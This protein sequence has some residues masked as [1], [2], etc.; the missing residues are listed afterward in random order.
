MNSTKANKNLPKSRLAKI[1]VLLSGAG[2]ASLP[3]SAGSIFK[4]DNVDLLSDSSSWIGG[5]APA[6]GDVAVFDSAVTV[7]GPF[8]LGASLSWAG[9]RVESPTANVEL[10]AGSSLSLGAAGVDLSDASR[11]LAIQGPL[12]LSAAQSWTLSAGRNVSV[13]G[14]LSR[15]NGV[16]VDFA[17]SEGSGVLLS[18]VPPVALLQGSTSPYATLNRRDFAG[19]DAS[20]Q[21]VPGAQVIAYAPNPAVDLP[22]MAGT[23]NGVID[24]VNSGSYGIRLGNTL[25]VTQ[26]IRFSAPHA[27]S[28]RW[29]VD[30]PSGRTLSV[31]SILVT[32]EVGEDRV[33]IS[34]TG[35]LRGNNNQAAGGLIIH[36]HNPVAE[37]EVAVPISNFGG[38][39]TPLTKTGAGVLTLS[40]NSTYTGSTHV[41]GGTLLVRGDNSAATGMVMVNAPAQLSGTGSVGG[42]TTIR[43]GAV[44]ASD[45]LTFKSAL[46]LQ[47]DCIFQID[48]TETRGTD[49][50][51][52]TVAATGSLSYGGR[53]AV[54]L[55]QILAPGDYTLKLFDFPGTPS[56][57]FETV[58]I[59]GAYQLTLVDTGGVWAGATGGVTFS[60]SQATGELTVSVPVT[61]TNGTLIL[62]SE[63][64]PEAPASAPRAAAAPAPSARESVQS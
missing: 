32:P 25:T 41:Q 39:F 53:L 34:G 61:Q 60:Y 26:G 14:D 38:S 22:T 27:T 52:V 56:G 9:V 63:H 21:L 30:A 42:S 40:G 58:A 3:L 37:L 64:R 47:G 35:Y 11:D 33:L 7:P 5:V 6:A 20:G 4:A 10:S 31:G 44:L 15:A 49:Y 12:I 45:S 28:T 16:T 46:T 55:N 48:G 29:L 13:G 62:I 1:V 57:S 54:S 18:G 8:A 43:P 51:A 19:V 59:T 17:L 2:A 23:V 36:Q 50:D 24:V